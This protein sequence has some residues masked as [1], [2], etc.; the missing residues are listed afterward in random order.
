[1]SRYV[2]TGAAGFIGSHLVAALLDRSDDVVGIDAFTDY[3]PRE[4]KEANLARGEARRGFEF[5]ELDLAEAD[6]APLVADADGVFHLAA[7]PGVRGSWGDTFAV[8]VRDNIVATQRL[9]ETS[10]R[11]GTRVV[12]ASSS[13]VYGNAET[14]PTVEDAPLHPVSPYGVTKLA[15]EK[16]AGAYRES[17]GLD[18]V[19]LR[20]FTVYGPGQRPDMA[21]ARIVAALQTDTPF[22]LFGTGEQSRDFTYV[23]DAVAATLAAMK[24]A[25]SSPVYNVGGGSEAT[26]GEVIAMCEDL[27]G[28]TLDL[29]GEPVAPGDVRRTAAD[30]SLIRSDLGWSPQTSLADGL[31]AQ[32]ASA[33]SQAQRPLQGPEDDCAD[34]AGAQA[35]GDPEERDLAATVVEEIGESAVREG[36]GWKRGE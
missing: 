3:Y 9:L 28:T 30:T 5:L 10:A 20:Y 16:L 8:Y 25:P 15:C 19:S 24:G 35:D 27:S 17:A 29:R 32:L 2:V 12:Q 22:H 11:A 33:G 13:S 7:Q 34:G 6:L 1:M 4:L 23:D 36:R 21:F 14:Y 31:A 26:L 18:V